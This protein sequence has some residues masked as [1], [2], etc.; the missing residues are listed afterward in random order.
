MVSLMPQNLINL[1][2]HLYNIMLWKT[3]LNQEAFRLEQQKQHSLSGMNQWTNFIV[4]ETK[5]QGRS[6]SNG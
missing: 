5:V 6:S 1:D 4:R 3:L 2:S